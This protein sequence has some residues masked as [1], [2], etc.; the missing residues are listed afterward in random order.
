MGEED[1]HVDAD[2]TG[3]DHRDAPARHD[4]A[5]EHVGV[6]RHARVVD[7]GDLR[8]PGHDAG[9]DDD[10]VEADEV[11]GRGECAEAYV[12]AEHLEAAGEVAQRLGELL[13]AGHRHREAELAAERGRL[14]EE[15]H[16]EAALRGAGRR[17]E[18]G[19]AR[20]D[21]GDGLLAQGRHQDE[22][23]LVAG[24][25]VDQAGGALVGED[26]VEAGLVAGD[27]GVDL[28]G[29]LVHRLGDERRVGQQRPRHRH[30]VG[31]TG[32]EDVLGELGGVDP[33]GGADRHVDDLLETGGVRPPG[34]TRDLRDD[35]GHACL[36]PA[37]AGV[38]DGDAGG[39]EVQGEL[40]DLV[41]GLAALDE[42]EQRDP[43]DD[44]EVVA[45]QL[46]R[47]AYDLDG[48]VHPARGRSA[49][50]VVAVVG[51]RGEELVDEV[52]L[53]THDLDRVVAGLARQRDALGEGGRGVVDLL[54]RHRVRLERRD[55]RLLVR[56]ALRQRVVAVAAGVQHLQ[57]D[58]A[59]GL[60]DRARH[61]LVS[62]R[63]QPVG[64]LRG[65]RLEP[66]ALR[67]GVPAGD[68]QPD[69]T[70]SPLLEE[71][72]ELVDVP[73]VV[74]ESGVHRAHHDAVAQ[75]ERVGT[76][77]EGDRRQQVGVEGVGHAGASLIWWACR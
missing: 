9:R 5:A 11:V 28:V 37:D 3:A 64:H 67:G 21:D 76:A 74:L 40:G 47:A 35:R 33:V 13:L 38:E 77:A 48:E 53:G 61:A 20:A 65:E 19:R 51:A 63:V 56:R 43:V 32:G 7:A 30:E 26:V 39:L 50:L 75:G 23:G 8:H 55:R 14:L 72:R 57:R 73:G 60:V 2:A 66:A 44:R 6:R 52:A 27:A 29:A 45:H 18:A 4:R 15:G 22:L 71:R 70:T 46:A 17:G 16:R 42:V 24:A 49:P 36:V 1:A 58:R 25:W 59:A 69:P 62:R 54:A 41:P 68:D 31:L 12:D 10:L 34:A